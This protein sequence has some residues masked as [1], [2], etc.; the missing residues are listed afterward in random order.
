MT[1]VTVSAEVATASGCERN[2]VSLSRAT[3]WTGR[4]DVGRAPPIRSCS[5]PAGAGLAAVQTGGR[6]DVTQGR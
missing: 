3:T 1:D 4:P 6:G 2:P 5:A